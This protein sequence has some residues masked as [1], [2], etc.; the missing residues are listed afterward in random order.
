MKSLSGVH[1][2]TV[3]CVALLYALPLFAPAIAHSQSA[4]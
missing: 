4:W 2:L 3:R 1:S